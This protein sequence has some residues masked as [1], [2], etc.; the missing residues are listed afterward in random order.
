MKKQ[1]I[2]TMNRILNFVFFFMFVPVVFYLIILLLRTIYAHFFISFIILFSF[3]VVF[4]T[5]FLV[6]IIHLFWRFLL[7]KYAVF[8]NLS[9][10]PRFFKNKKEIGSFEVTKNYFLGRYYFDKADYKQAEIYFINSLNSLFYKQI[11][12]D[13]FKIGSQSYDDRT[14]KK[15]KN[16][17]D[18]LYEENNG[19]I[20]FF[21]TI[22]L[23]FLQFLSMAEEGVDWFLLEKKPIIYFIKTRKINSINY[24][25]LHNFNEDEERFKENQQAIFEDNNILEQEEKE[26][27]FINTV[28]SFDE[29]VDFICITSIIL[30]EFN[31]LEYYK[32]AIKNCTKCIDELEKATNQT[33]LWR[34]LYVRGCAYHK[35]GEADLACKDWK[36]GIELGD[37]EFSQEMY[38]ENCK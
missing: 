28:K 18:K 21:K 16:K 7:G 38:D 29:T 24:G 25:F 12:L 37:V 35:L 36:R 1:K 30:L 15:M 31:K 3:Y 13:D 32:K 5:L 11:I 33:I 2:I 26:K 34:L 19:S 27:R 23:Y 22:K 10:I 20:A 4:G 17:V 8:Y 9:L 6:F 14:K